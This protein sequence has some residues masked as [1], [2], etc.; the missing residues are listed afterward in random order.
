MN[1]FL[2]PP[3]LGI[4]YAFVFGSMVGSYLNVVV[5]RVP[6]GLSTWRPRS[7][8]P[9]CDRNI[10]WFDNVPIISY[11]GLRARCRH[12]KTPISFRYPVVEFT[13]GLLFALAFIR[14]GWN[15]TTIVAF[16]L[17]ALL[18]SLALIDAEHLLLPDLITLPGLLLGLAVSGSSDLTSPLS[19][20]LGALIGATALLGLIAIYYLLKGELGMGLGDPKMLAMIGSFLGAPKTVVTLVLASFAGTAVSL[21]LMAFGRANS[22]T[23][24]PFGVYLAIG[25]TAA[26]FF[27][28]RLVAAYLGL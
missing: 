16:C 22:R 1:A 12:C 10:A 21:A 6:R 14:F 23:R 3:S 4:F 13:T 25:A 9:Q 26:L 15:V 7:R 2:I 24:L 18:V 17:L 28:D 19:A 27:G 20:G 8:C 11:L 5:Y